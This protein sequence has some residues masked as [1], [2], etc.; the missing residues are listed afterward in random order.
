MNIILVIIFSMIGFLIIKSSFCN[1]EGFMLSPSPS[2]SEYMCSYSQWSNTRREQPGM[3]L[4]K[5]WVAADCSVYDIDNPCGRCGNF[6]YS[7]EETGLGLCQSGLKTYS[8][9]FGDWKQR[10]RKDHCQTGT[11]GTCA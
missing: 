9:V 7:T 8:D 6:C 2:P 4:K 11:G 5:G 1:C 3:D 10:M